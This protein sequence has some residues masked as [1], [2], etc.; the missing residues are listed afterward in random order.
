M[1]VANDEGDRALR[2]LAAQGDGWSE[3]QA[4]YADER[5]M[6]PWVAY[7]DR[8]VGML[9][10][11]VV[12]HQKGRVGTE[13]PGGKVVYPPSDIDVTI[14][15]N[16][17][18]GDPAEGIARFYSRFREQFGAEPVTLLDVNVYDQIP[19]Y[20]RRARWW[21]ML[22]PIVHAPTVREQLAG[23]HD[24]VSLG[25]F[26]RSVSAETWSRFVG[27]VQEQLT[28]S[29]AEQ[30]GGRAHSAQQTVT[31]VE[32]TLADARRAFCESH[33]CRNPRDCLQRVMVDRY[34]EQLRPTQLKYVEQW[35]VLSQLQTAYGPVRATLERRAEQLEVEIG[36][37]QMRGRQFANSQYSSAGALKHVV[38]Q[39]QGVAAW[40]GQSAALPDRWELLAS[41]VE[42]LGNALREL[43]ELRPRGLVEA[44]RWSSKYVGRFLSASAALLPADTSLG[45]EVRGL[46]APVEKVA[47]ARR[48]DAYFAPPSRQ[49]A[50]EAEIARTWRAIDVPD[51]ERALL[52]LGIATNVWVRN[53]LSHTAPQRG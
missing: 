53:H 18:A 27:G 21:P 40:S 46:C 39:L 5:R 30:F 48:D 52:E 7:R 24:E 9:L 31:Q 29:A 35:E 41:A 20:A 42:N 36:I 28:A 37:L 38:G 50:L 8:L 2:R 25:R 33:P 47:G 1:A 44:F 11:E 49:R 10:D 51:L 22:A 32:A 34:L 12:Q 3:L 14:Y 17:G 26:F 13:I 6:A 23:V 16:E 45:R 4:H 43:C 19:L 15:S